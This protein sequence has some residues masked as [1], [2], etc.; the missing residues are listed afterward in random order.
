MRLGRTRAERFGAPRLSGR[1]SSVGACALALI[2]FGQP[3]AARADVHKDA[4]LRLGAMARTLSGG[5]DDASIGPLVAADAH[6]A[7]LPLLR[8]GAFLSHDIAPSSRFRDAWRRHGSFGLSVRTNAPWPNRSVH[9]WL[10][11]RAGPTLTYADGYPALG[12]PPGGGSAAFGRVDG[13]WGAFLEVPAGVG[14]AVRL[15]KPFELSMEIG[16][17][18][19]A[20]H[21][22]AAYR[23]P[24]V[25]IAGDPA[26]LAPFRG[27]ETFAIFAALGISYD[28]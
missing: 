8:A 3:R 20:F 4:S 11:L 21:G 27:R 24:E 5:T 2:L 14:G 1:G 16:I 12:A 18:L 26:A 9:L 23:Q 19:G 22:G 28:R 13:A 17:R 25:T 10:F 7:L 6:V 15:R